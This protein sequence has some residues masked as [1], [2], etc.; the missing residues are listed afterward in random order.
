MSSPA[1]TTRNLRDKLSA[2]FGFKQFRPGQARVVRAALEGRDVV[3]IMPT[4]SGKSLCFQLP[5]MELPGITLIISPLIALMK[6]QVDRLRE[7]GIRAT[8]INST[9]SAEE[10][11]DVEGRIASGDIDFVYTTPE[12]I[13]VP[14]HRE[15]LARRTIDLFVVD[16][17]HCVSQWGHSFRPDYLSL[18]VA[19][20]DLGNPPVLALT[21]SATDEIISDIIEQLSI[22]NA[23]VVHTGFYRPNITLQIKGVEGEA[24]KDSG[25]RHF[26][27]REGS[28]IVYAATTATVERI[29]ELLEGTGK[30][31]AAYHG[32]M[33]AKRRKDA[34]DR[35]MSGDADVMVATNAFGLGIDKADIRFVAHYHLPGSIE[36][37][38]QEVSRSGRDGLPA[39]AIA[40]YDPSDEKLQRFLQATSYPDDAD[41]VNAYHAL[42]LAIER[43]PCATADAIFT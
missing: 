18:G 26:I 11:R 2:H 25:L 19:I 33:A 42:E 13:A 3:V 14:E 4:G 32:R 37:Y 38:Y 9:L 12:R 40:F 30:K 10:L 36:A 23:E 7:Q 15:L 5:G 34:Q 43:D 41:L 6:D 20:R 22:P 17:A 39:D 28:G 35:F 1:I 29:A 24:E 27:R 8:F 21:A 16:E 31:I